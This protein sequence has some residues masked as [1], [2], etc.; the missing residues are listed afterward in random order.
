NA[1]FDIPVIDAGNGLF[2]G[3]ALIEWDSSAAEVAVPPTEN[4]P[5]RDLDDPHE[6]ARRAIEA[7]EQKMLYLRSN[8]QIR[9]LCG[10]SD[11]SMDKRNYCYS[12]LKE[13]VQL[14]TD[15]LVDLDTVR[16][17]LN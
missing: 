1:F 9:P 16:R 2:G 6:H 14:P 5:P 4:T 12:G 10:T 13:R 15:S 8:G 11:Y 3:S 7:R 17:A